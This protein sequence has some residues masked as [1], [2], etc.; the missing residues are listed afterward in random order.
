MKEA[1]HLD[2]LANVP[3]NAD[4]NALLA[5]TYPNI[6]TLDSA[7]L[8]TLKEDSHNLACFFGKSHSHSFNYGSGDFLSLFSTLFAHHYHIALAPSL[9]QQSFYA[10]ELFKHIAPQGLSFLPLNQQ[11]II[12]SAR[13]NTQKTQYVFF[14]PLINQDILSH[15]PIESLIEQILSTH[16]R[17][18]IFID[19]S[20]FISTLSQEKCAFLRSLQNPQ[21]VLLC[22]GESIALM[23]PSGFIVSDF[24]K[25]DSI[26][27]ETL[28]AFFNTTLLRPHLF[29]AANYALECIVS[30]P[31]I[32]ESKHIF[33]DCLKTHLGENISLFAPLELTAQNAL[34]LRFKHIK[35]RLLIQALSIE[36]IYAINGQDCLFGNAKPS[37]VLRSMGYDEPSTR[38]LLSVSY[39]HLD[40]IE[41]TA[42]ILAQAYTQL[43]QFHT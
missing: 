30:S 42:Y 10:A 9:H 26:H 13:Q 32:Q 17:A 3:L 28:E 6:N 35:A 5:D 43:R 37:F 2:F 1:I 24:D 23:R 12:E 40:S 14:M 16:P 36:G 38:E 18:L 39:I 11:G 22:N 7:N 29:K 4:A 27:K 34:P 25:L 8:H 15:N 21:I 20:L 31:P 19:I 41:S 33:F